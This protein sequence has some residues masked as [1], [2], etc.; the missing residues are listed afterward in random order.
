[1]GLKPW[2]TGNSKEILVV[3]A[4]RPFDLFPDALQVEDRSKTR[5]RIV[6]TESANQRVARNGWYRLGWQ[7]T[8]VGMSGANNVRTLP[9]TI[10][11]FV[12]GASKFLS[13]CPQPFH[14]R[15]EEGGVTST[16]NLQE[17]RASTPPPFSLLL[18]QR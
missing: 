14:H 3:V 17:L 15:G 11:P 7:S 4:A 8:H 2:L 10:Q 12:F 16:S 5:V 18:P 6:Q 9:S 13:Q 1:M